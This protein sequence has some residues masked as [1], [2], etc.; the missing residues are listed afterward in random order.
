MSDLLE[1]LIEERHGKTPEDKRVAD[2]LTM[3][4]E[5]DKVKQDAVVARIERIIKDLELLKSQNDKQYE[6]LRDALRDALK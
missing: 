6:R 1:L 5:I 4:G 3:K 2:F